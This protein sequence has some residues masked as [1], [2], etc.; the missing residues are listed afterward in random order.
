LVVDTNSRMLSESAAKARV[1]H[2]QTVMGQRFGAAL[3]YKRV[4]SQLRGS[5]MDEVRAWRAAIGVPMIVASSAPAYDFTT[6]D[7]RQCH[8]GEALALGARSDDH[9]CEHPRDLTDLPP[10]G[11]ATVR[12]AGLPSLL[13]GYLRA[14]RD[15]VVD[16]ATAEDL[17]AIAQAARVLVDKGARL[18]LVGSYGF[19][20][21]WLTT[22][23]RGEESP[24]PGVLTLATSRRP[25]TRGQVAAL[26]RDARTVTVPVAGTPSQVSSD[27]AVGSAS[28]P[29]GADAAIDPVWNDPPDGSEV[30]ARAVDALRSGLNVTLTTSGADGSAP[31]TSSPEVA[32]RAAGLAA[33]VL[34]QIRP[35][36]LILMGGEGASALIGQVKMSRLDVVCEPWP[37]TPVLRLRGGDHDGLLAVIQSGS[38]GDPTRPLH[39]IN[40]LSALSSGSA[41]M[42]DH[43]LTESPT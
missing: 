16:S 27:D 18:G 12:S 29:G 11:L 15:V 8:H 4:D 34:R 25:A 28:V 19:L 35:T 21:A 39:A 37:A 22:R 26:A 2:V 9:A 42:S 41:S 17:L 43:P 7:G 20:S 40:L 32:L 38:Q 33:R 3:A 36:G 14:E 13:N 5:T 10:L 30:V 1:G 24:T 23:A 31:T 6:I